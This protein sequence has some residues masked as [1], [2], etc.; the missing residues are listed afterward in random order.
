MPI[1]EPSFQA[2]LYLKR[3]F[4]AMSTSLLHRRRAPHRLETFAINFSNSLP[5]VGDRAALVPIHLVATNLDAPRQLC[6]HG[7]ST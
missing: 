2:F 7:Y 5:G 1:V 3:D 4:W 6:C